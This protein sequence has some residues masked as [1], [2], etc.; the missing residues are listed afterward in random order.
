MGSDDIRDV[1]R[2]YTDV[3]ADYAQVSGGEAA[4]AYATLA[5]ACVRLEDLPAGD[6]GEAVAV[7]AFAAAA[8]AF[9]GLVKRQL[10]TLGRRG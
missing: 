4:D 3:C 1:A 7:D 9:N 5:E 2:V 8:A 6:A 10:A